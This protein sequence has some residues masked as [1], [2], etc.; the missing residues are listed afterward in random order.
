[1]ETLWFIFLTVL[2]TVYVV[3]DGYDLGAGAAHIFVAKTEAERQTVFRTI[4]PFWDGNEVFLLAAGGTMFAAFPSAY[5]ASFSGFYLPLMFV[6]WLLIFR[7]IAI[8]LRSHMD[9]PLWKQ[10]W[11]VAF[12][13]ASALL[14]IFFGA[15]LGNVIRGVPLDD[16]GEFFLSLW[17]HFGVQGEVGILDW[18]TI[19]VALLA[20][21][22]L[23]M[24]GCFWIVLK[25]SGELAGR[26]RQLAFRAGVATAVLTIPVTAATFWVQPQIAN[27]L[28]QHSWGAGFPLLAL[29]GLAG[30][31]LLRRDELKAFLSSSLYLAGM[32]CSGAFGVFPYVLP[33]TRGNGMTATSAAAGAYGLTGAL[34]WWIPGML[35]TTG[36]FVCVYRHFRGKVTAQLH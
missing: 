18:Y 20:L 32:M 11:D 26:A 6:L 29:I 35:L 33:S 2:L 15:A 10:L 5:A 14:A 34:V 17:T 13:S 8:E 3:L 30:A 36:Y 27:N 16:K 31:L 4:G 7:G 19:L 22:A 9:N 24:H 21:A 28:K 23:V 25:A 1:M 12:F